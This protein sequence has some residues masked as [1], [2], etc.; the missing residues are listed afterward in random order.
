MVATEAYAIL[1]AHIGTQIQIVL[2]GERLPVIVTSVDPDG[3]LF[4]PKGSGP[5]D[6]ASEFWVAFDHIDAIEIPP[7]APN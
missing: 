2:A 5:R 6:A 7:S 4:R 3:A 1:R